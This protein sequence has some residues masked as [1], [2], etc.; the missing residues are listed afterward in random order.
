MQLKDLKLKNKIVYYS[1]IIVIPIV[2]DD[3]LLA[4]LFENQ[5]L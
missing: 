4:I 5:V 3:K 2:K 1:F